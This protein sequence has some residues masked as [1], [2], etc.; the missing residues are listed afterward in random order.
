MTKNENAAIAMAKIK[1]K[2]YE[3]VKNKYVRK[4]TNPVEKRVM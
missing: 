2:R 4:P 1:Q 3:K